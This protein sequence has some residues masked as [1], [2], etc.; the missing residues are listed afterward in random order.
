MNDTRIGP[1]PSVPPAAGPDPQPRAVAVEAA[2]ELDDLARLLVRDVETSR[3]ARAQ[4][5]IEALLYAAQLALAR[6]DGSGLRGIASEA[7]RIARDLGGGDAAAALVA[8]AGQV[9][10]LCEKPNAPATP[11]NHQTR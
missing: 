9:C 3:L 1:A 8:Q 4:S 2:A 7:G 10:R 5:Q 11:A 6:G